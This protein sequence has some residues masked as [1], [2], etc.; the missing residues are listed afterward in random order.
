MGPRGWGWYD[1]LLAYHGSGGHLGAQ[2]SYL[3]AEPLELG[4][5]VRAEGS[6]LRHR[7]TARVCRHQGTIS[8]SD[9]SGHHPWWVTLGE[10][11]CPS[12][13]EIAENFTPVE[14][15]IRDSGVNRVGK[16]QLE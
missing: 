9:G 12:R 7:R 11:G 6:I 1:N 3:G 2:V 10:G 5:F 4:P 16:T 8:K 15:V 13:R 14:L